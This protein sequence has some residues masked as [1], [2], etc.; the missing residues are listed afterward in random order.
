MKR[1]RFDLLFMLEAVVS[2]GLAL[3]FSWAKQPV[4]AILW[5]MN[6]NL[7]LIC[8]YLLGVKR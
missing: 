5:L 6:G 8:Y 7:S 1:I 3:L 4:L 2:G